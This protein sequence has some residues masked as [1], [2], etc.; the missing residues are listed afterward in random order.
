MKLR[1]YVLGGCLV[2][3]S[4]FASQSIAQDL[5]PA[6]LG[7]GYAHLLTTVAQPEIA[8]SGVNIDTDTPGTDVTLDTLHIPYYTEFGEE[9]RHWHMQASGG[10]AIYEQDIKL[11]HRPRESELRRR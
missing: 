8:A 10:Y 1:T 4:L 9:G 5:D 2:Q 11:Q 6:D 3:A 7:A